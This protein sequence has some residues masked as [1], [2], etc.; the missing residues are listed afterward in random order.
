MLREAWL[1]KLLA[2]SSNK[3][4]VWQYQSRVGWQSLEPGRCRS[5]AQ[6]PQASKG[7]LVDGDV[8]VG[9][10][11]QGVKPWASKSA[12]V[13]NVPVQLGPLSGHCRG[14]PARSQTLEPQSCDKAGQNRPVKG[15][16][17]A[18]PCC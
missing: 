2:Q 3:S 15:R 13:C 6:A 16:N 8:R 7:C 1:A 12:S 9:G 18:G 14:L 4:A 10:S 5:A 17:G 11:K